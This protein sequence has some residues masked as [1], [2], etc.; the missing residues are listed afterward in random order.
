MYYSK[1][2]ITC[3]RHR[4]IGSCVDYVGYF[5]DLLMVQ[6]LIIYLVPRVLTIFSTP[7]S[8]RAAGRRRHAHR[9]RWLPVGSPP[10]GDFFL[11]NDPKL[12]ILVLK[13][14]FHVFLM[15]FLNEIFHKILKKTWRKHEENMKKIFRSDLMKKLWK[16][17]VF[18]PKKK[19]FII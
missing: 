12:C 10:L 5:Y 19:N 1:F 18:L 11:R 16:N 13:S 7:F 9:P 3:H 2:L 4:C 8:P 17:I 14:L 6:N 15:G